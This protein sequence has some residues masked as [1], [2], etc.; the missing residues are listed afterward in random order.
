MITKEDRQG[1]TTR[2]RAL[3]DAAEEIAYFP[4]GDP[5]VAQF[6]NQLKKA[7]DGLLN[8]DLED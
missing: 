1:R 7:L 4:F 2:L 6:Q 3:V 5:L 8:M